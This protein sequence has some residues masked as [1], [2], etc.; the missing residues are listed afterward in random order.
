MRRTIAALGLALGLVAPLLVMSPAQAVDDVFRVAT[1][2]I[3]K[4]MTSAEQESD[5]YKMTV[6]NNVADV[7]L[8]QEISDAST[9]A[10]LDSLDT[11]GWATS[12]VDS[13]IPISFR[14]SEFKWISASLLDSGATRGAQVVWAVLEH[15]PTGQ[16]YRFVNNHLRAGSDWDNNDP[17]AATQAIRDD[18]WTTFNFTDDLIDGWMSDGVYT[19][20]L[21]GGDFN[22]VTGTPLFAGSQEWL[23]NGTIDKLYAIP[24]G[25]TDDLGAIAEPSGMNTDHGPRIR[26]VRIG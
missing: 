4:T 10:Y 17:D 23:H 8:W 21:G 16:R 19:R 25:L 1:A 12:K 18:W 9:K 7:I 24:A 13:H 3:Q 2:N 6:G 22:R 5:I 26:K 14:K 11:Q 20:I 15:R